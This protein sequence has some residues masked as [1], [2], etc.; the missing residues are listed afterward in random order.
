MLAKPGRA[1]PT[2][3]RKYLVLAWSGDPSVTTSCSQPEAAS[4]I[5]PYSLHNAIWA[6]SNVVRCRNRLPFWTEP[7]SFLSHSPTI[8]PAKQVI[9]FIRLYFR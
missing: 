2:G 8:I 5:G 3:D 9:D 6:W 7:L 4:E 1:A